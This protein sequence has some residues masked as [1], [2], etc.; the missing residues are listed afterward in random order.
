MNYFMTHFYDADS[1]DQVKHEYQHYELQTEREVHNRVT[2]ILE[3]LE[4]SYDL[5]ITGIEDILTFAQQDPAIC[6]SIDW[7][8]LKKKLMKRKIFLKRDYARNRGQFSTLKKEIYIFTNAE[9]VKD[10]KE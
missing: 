5:R 2:Q 1:Q 8:Q 9:V 3:H 6:Q 7:S 4:E 10:E